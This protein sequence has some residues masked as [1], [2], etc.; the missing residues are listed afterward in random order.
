[1]V[2]LT[3]NTLRIVTPAGVQLLSLGISASTF[4]LTKLDLGV[5]ADRGVSQPLP[6]MDGEVDTSAFVGAR[7]IVAEV[8]I[9]G[10][11]TGLLIDQLAAVTHPGARNYAYVGRSDWPGGERRTLVRG[12]P[13]PFPPGTVRAAQLTFRAPSGLFE[14]AT[15]TTYRLTPSGSATGGM[16][17][18]VS[19]PMTFGSGQV[20]GA[21]SVTTS[22]TAPTPVQWRL[23]GPFQ[24]PVVSR[25]DTGEQ[26]SFPGLTVAAGDYLS[27]DTD[28]RTVLLNDNPANSLYGSLD[29][30]TATWW[31]LPASGTTPVLFTA[32][33][34]SAATNGVLTVRNRYL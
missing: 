9:S 30:S 20:A 17:F 15:A 32:D 16:S 33:A 22:G 4:I 1:V 29:F 28:A 25:R 34:S 26:L 7:N 18:P 12:V 10:V 3:P 27:I 13:S 24:N 23:Y 21:S 19:F 2:L 11:N 6:G 31:R 8:T 14:D 5:P